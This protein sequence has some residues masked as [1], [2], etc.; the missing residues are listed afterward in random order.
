MPN[1]ILI[2]YGE[3]EPPKASLDIAELGY[4][5]QNNKFYVGIGEENTFLINKI[6]EIGEESEVSSSEIKTL[7]LDSNKNNALYPRTRVEAIKDNGGN[8]LIAL[9]DAKQKKHETLTVTLIASKWSNN[10]QEVSVNG[11]NET[12]TI[13][14]CPAPENMLDYT[15]NEVY[16]LG[17]GKE[18]LTFACTST[19]KINLIVNILIFS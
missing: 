2:K 14:V 5:I 3:G 1:K 4:D 18:K 15:I 16:C 17:Q 13:I 19:P 12:N 10:K 9:L 8:E 11:V 6:N 7:F